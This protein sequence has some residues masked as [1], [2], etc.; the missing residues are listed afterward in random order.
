MSRESLAA[1][2]AEMYELL[3]TPAVPA[4]VTAAYDHEPAR[5]HAQKPVAVTLFTAG[6]DGINYLIGLR[7]YVT[8]DIDART[9]QATLDSVMLAVDARMLLFGPS[10]WESEWD[11]ELG[12]FTA[13]NVFAVGREDGELRIVS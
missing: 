12:A 7:I 13:T 3:T 9:A 4:G 10:E 11:A 8:G 1:A 5:G 6:M 2:K